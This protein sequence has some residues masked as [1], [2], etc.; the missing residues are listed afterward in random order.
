MMIKAEARQKNRKEVNHAPHQRK[1]EQDEQPINGLPGANGMY[2]EKRGN[3]YVKSK[4]G[5]C[6]VHISSCILS[7]S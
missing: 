1:Q 7:C 3:N 6:Y 5:E 4:T 2:R